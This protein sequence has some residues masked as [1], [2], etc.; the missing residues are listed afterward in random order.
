ML[1]GKIIRA[2]FNFFD[3]AFM[4][5]LEAHEYVALVENIALLKA[6]SASLDHS[7]QQVNMVR[8]SNKINHIKPN[9]SLLLMLLLIYWSV[10]YVSYIEV[11]ISIGNFHIR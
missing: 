11:Q 7:R 10:C 2:S 4:M 1:R 6:V 8:C 3:K 5:L 9:G